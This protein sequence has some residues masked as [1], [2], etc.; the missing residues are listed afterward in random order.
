MET[1]RKKWLR[2]AMQG[3]GRRQQWSQFTKVL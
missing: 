2:N 3:S 1:S